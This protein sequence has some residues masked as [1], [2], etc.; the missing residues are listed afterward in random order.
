V[1]VRAAAFSLLLAAAAAMLT[2]AP[3][4]GVNPALT[5][6][7]LSSEK[8]GARPVSA[9]IT[10]REAELQCGRLVG[11]SLVVTFP[12]QMRVPRA[13]G[14]ASVLV[15]TKAARSV[16]VSGRVVTV[17][18]PVPRGVIC[19]SITIGVAKLTFT[20]AAGLG[21]PKSPGA[22]LFRLRRGA[23]TSGSFFK[24]A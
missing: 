7:A 19:D 10:I 13:I 18:V 20:R 8:A 23:D 9:T 6:M 16:T 1:D 11:G 4:L 5:T 12:R 17:A 3:A 21:N 14:A 15:G 24:I 22:Y 2:A